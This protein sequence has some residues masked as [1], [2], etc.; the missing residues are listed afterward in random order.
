MEIGDDGPG[1]PPDVLP[2]IFE[3]FFTTKNI[4]EGKGLGLDAA[5]RIVV[6]RHR[7][8]IHVESRPGDTR[9]QV[10]LPLAG[11]EARHERRPAVPQTHAGADRM[12]SAVRPGECAWSPARRCS[13]RATRRTSS[14][15][16]ME[17]ELRITKTVAG[18]G[19]D[20]ARPS[21]RASS[22]GALSM[23]NDGISIATGRAT[24]PCR[25]LRIDRDGF[26]EMFTACPQ[27]TSTILFAMA[28]RRPEAETLT[29]Q[30]EKLAA[31]GKLS[32]GLAHELNNPAAAARRAAGQLRETLHELAAA[33]PEAGRA[34]PE[35]ETRAS[36]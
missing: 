15:V 27:V 32:A 33:H 19:D 6:A 30:R 28:E 4:G 2:R 13:P 16:V 5:Y 35:P 10:R 8:D 22:P 24:Q 12:P 36:G 3:P 20:A 31:L 11:V 7:G 29:R 14:I 23:F 25:L 26:K 18:G 21:G 1:I 34:V 17:G 9:F